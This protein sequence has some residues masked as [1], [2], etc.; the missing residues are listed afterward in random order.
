MSWSLFWFSI[1]MIRTIVGNWQLETVT[2]NYVGNNNPFIKWLNYSNSYEWCTWVCQLT[3]ESTVN[4]D[5][6]IEYVIKYVKGAYVLS[7][8]KPICSTE[9]ENTFWFSNLNHKWVECMDLFLSWYKDGTVSC[10]CY[11]TKIT[12]SWNCEKLM[13]NLPM[14]TV[15]L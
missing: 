12:G 1:S 2:G 8:L 3:C 6:N 9:V 15:C 5:L 11:Q 10:P 4:V 14:N 7:K 13:T